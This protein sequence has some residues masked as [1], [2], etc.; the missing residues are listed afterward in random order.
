[1]ITNVEQL[2]ALSERFIRAATRI[3]RRNTRDRIRTRD[4]AGSAITFS[5]PLVSRR[6]SR[7]RKPPVNQLPTLLQGNH[8]GH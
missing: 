3:T 1:M 6:S 8:G 5:Q 4:G 2:N 7:P